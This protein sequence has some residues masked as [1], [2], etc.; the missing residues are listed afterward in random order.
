[1]HSYLKMPFVVLLVGLLIACQ[2]HDD[3]AQGYI[4]GR[5]TYIAT[6]VSGILNTLYVTK[7]A[8]VNRGQK[9][10]ALES[11]PESDIYQAE[12]D[13]LRQAS[14]AR[15]AIS[16][17][18]TY[19]K[20]TYERYKTL[21]PKGAIQQSA[22][23]NAKANYH[24]ALSQLAEAQASIAESRAKVAQ[25]KWTLEQKFLYAPTDGIVFD[26]F[27]RQGEYTE[28]K[29]AILSLLAPEDIKA[30]FYVPQRILGQFQL[31]QAISI[32]C[33]GC[34]TFYPAKISFISPVAEYTPPVIF[35]SETNSKLI[36]R[37]EANFAR[38]DAYHLHPGQ[39]IRVHYQL[40]R[41]D[42]RTV[43]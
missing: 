22:L 26:T 20:L 11:Q 38:Q 17:N 1:M 27:Y 13:N 24:S 14:A 30:I 2:Q 43:G 41:H 7:G 36:Y 31:G 32:A 15:D 37:I 9:L 10:I 18:L 40:N 8:R 16:A 29:K 33:D 4:E 28:A 5:Y 23:D 3:E 12:I 19:L 35:S 6:N 39:P 21:V 34:S 42:R 25:A